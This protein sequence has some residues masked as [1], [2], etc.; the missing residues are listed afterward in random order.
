MTDDP[1]TPWVTCFKSHR[2]T[3]DLAFYC[4]SFA[5]GI[6]R[7]EWEEW[8][9]CQSLWLRGRPQT[10]G[11]KLWEGKVRPNNLKNHSNDVGCLILKRTA[12]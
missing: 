12:W 9:R 4:S 1:A 2:E 10:M 8:K 3:L 6:R 7:A 5:L 11:L